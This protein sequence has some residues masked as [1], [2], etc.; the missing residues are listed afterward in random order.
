MPARAACPPWSIE[1]HA[2]SFIVKDP[3]GQA[4][5]Y[6]YFDDEPQPPLADAGGVKLITRKGF[7]L[8]DV[9]RWPLAR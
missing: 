3:N 8:A 1:E 5:G 6:F 2:E 4:R 9:F 7:D